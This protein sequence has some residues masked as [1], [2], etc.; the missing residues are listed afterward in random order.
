LKTIVLEVSNSG[1]FN[2]PNELKISL[3]RTKSHGEED[4]KEADDETLLAWDI[5]IE[6]NFTN[7]INIAF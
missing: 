6:S 5:A 7:I 3:D 2:L 4:E 1:I